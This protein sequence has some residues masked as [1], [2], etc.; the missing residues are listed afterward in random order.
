MDETMSPF[1]LRILCDKG[2]FDIPS[3][4]YFIIYI[5]LF[6]EIMLNFLLFF[7]SNMANAFISIKVLR[8]L[9]TLQS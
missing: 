2:V 1:G 6:Y 7:C 5:Y 3:I 8:Y 4:I 9:N